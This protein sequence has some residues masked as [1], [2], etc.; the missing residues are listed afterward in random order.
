MFEVNDVRRRGNG[1][2]ID[3]C[4]LVALANLDGLKDH[5]V[6]A[7]SSLF[8]DPDVFNLLNEPEAAPVE[9]RNFH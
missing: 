3:A 1:R 4:N 2:R 8:P 9:N 6:P 7:Q 5:D